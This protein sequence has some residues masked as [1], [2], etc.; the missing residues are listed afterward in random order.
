MIIKSGDLF[1]AVV[2]LGDGMG[3]S[4]DMWVRHRNK[5]LDGWVVKRKAVR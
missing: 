3:T 5:G 4:S 1:M 2:S